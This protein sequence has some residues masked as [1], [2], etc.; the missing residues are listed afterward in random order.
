MKIAVIVYV[1]PPE[2]SPA[3]VMV[4]EQAEHLAASSVVSGTD[5]TP[6]N[7]PASL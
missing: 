6:R 5:M 1:Y 7:G 3:G 4:R 2:H